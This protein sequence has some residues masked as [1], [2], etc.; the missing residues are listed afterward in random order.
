MDYAYSKASSKLRSW[1]TKVSI[2]KGWPA[3][4]L[5]PMASLVAAPDDIAGMEL[6]VAMA[7]FNGTARQRTRCWKELFAADPKESLER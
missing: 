3:A 7:C 5:N 1:S 4:W 2:T 6:K